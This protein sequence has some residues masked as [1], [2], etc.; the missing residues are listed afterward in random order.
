MVLVW[1]FDSLADAEAWYT[2]PAYRAIIPDMDRS[3]KV[4]V[5]IVEGLP[6]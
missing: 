2:S 4:R 6:R 1:S 3:A 5:M